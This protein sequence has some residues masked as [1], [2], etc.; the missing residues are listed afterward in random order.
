[1][2]Q[3]S[4]IQFPAQ[5]IPAQP[6]HKRLIRHIPAAISLDLDREHEA[7]LQPSRGALVLAHLAHRQIALSAKRFKAICA[8]FFMHL[9]K[10]AA[11]TIL[12]TIYP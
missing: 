3:A 1:M 2:N 12:V 5:H 9:T 7:A 11:M 10:K 6:G 4:R 8:A